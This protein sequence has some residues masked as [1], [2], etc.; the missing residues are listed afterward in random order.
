MGDV[1]FTSH[2]SNTLNK[3]GVFTP[4]ALRCVAPR[5]TTP[6]R[7]AVQVIRCERTFNDAFRKGTFAHIL[8][9]ADDTKRTDDRFSSIRFA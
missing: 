9:T 7:T 2:Y 6:Q 3:P 1:S 4:G 5:C 8:R